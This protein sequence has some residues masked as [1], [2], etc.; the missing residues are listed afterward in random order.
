MTILPEQYQ[1]S[2]EA[3][4]PVSMGSAGLKYGPD[5]RVAWDEIWGSF[6]DLAMA[7]GPPHKGKLLEPGSAV[8]IAKNPAQYQTVVE[9]ITRGIRLASEVAVSKPKEPGWI[10]LDCDDETM[11]EWLL[12]AVTMENISCHWTGCTLSLPAGPDFRIAK[13]IKNVITTVAKTAHYWNGHMWGAQKEEIRKSFAKMKS[14]H[15]LIQPAHADNDQALFIKNRRYRG[16]HRP[17]DF[18]SPLFRLAGSKM[19]NPGSRRFG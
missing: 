14:E 13:E 18:R 15:P 1:D 12:R 16:R 10:P 7:G 3:I 17:F 19:R 11:A 5:G 9:E 8:E 4:Q 2:Y 6:C